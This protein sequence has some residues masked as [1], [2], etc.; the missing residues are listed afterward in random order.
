MLFIHVAIMS[1]C[2]PYAGRL[3]WLARRR[4]SVVG[5]HRCGGARGEDVG[6][7]I[8]STQIVSALWLKAMAA[9]NLSLCSARLDACVRAKARRSLLQLGFIPSA[10][11]WLWGLQRCQ[12]KWPRNIKALLFWVKPGF[13]FATVWFKRNKMWVW[14]VG[15]R[16]ERGGLFSSLSF[17]LSSM[18]LAHLSPA[19]AAKGSS[20]RY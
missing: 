4:R 16:G 13:P 6:W 9:R 18:A 19:M 10:I 7:E 11:Y 3:G 5:R 14:F 20:S 8:N 12:G 17:S 15:F 1:C 2:N